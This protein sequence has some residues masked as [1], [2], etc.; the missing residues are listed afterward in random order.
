[1]ALRG[2]SAIPSTIRDFLGQDSP[3]LME[4]AKVAEDAATIAELDERY[5]RARDDRRQYEGEWLTNLAFVKGQQW[6]EWSKQRQTLYQKP[7]PPWRIRVTVNLTQPIVRTLLGK[8]GAQTT[9]GRVQANSDTPEANMDA[10]AQDE[11][12]AH[13]RHVC[14]SEET[15]S[16]ALKW[17]LIA[18]T[19]IHHLCWDKS[20]GD[21]VLEPDTIMAESIDPMTGQPTQIEQPNPN[22]GQPLRE[23]PA[24]VAEGEDPKP[25]A[26]VHMGEIDHMPVSPLQFFPEPMAKTIDDAEWCFHV[27][28]RPSSYVMRKYGKKVEEERI[29][30]DDYLQITTDETAGQTKGVVVK[31]YWERPNAENPEGRYVVF[32]GQEVLVSGPNP[33]PKFPLPFIVERDPLIPDS[34]W[35]RALVADLVPLQRS[36]NKLKSQASEIRESIA[37]PKWHRFKNTMDAGVP[38]TTAPAEVIESIFQPTMPDGGRPT[39]IVGGDVPISYQ[40]EA[41]AIERQFFE[42]A[43]LHDFRQGTQGLAGGKTA[44]GL[45]LLIEQDD[46]R[47]G[48]L[49]REHDKAVLAS[50]TAMLKL[51]KQFYIEPRTVTVVGPD[52]AVEVNE[53]YS[54]KISDDPQ[55]RLVASGNL[56]TSMAARAEYIK[57]L[58]TTQVMPGSILSDPRAIRKLLNLADVSGVKDT[59]ETDIRQ[60]ER[61]NELMKQG[62]VPAAHNYD[63]H[64]VHGQEHDDY[65]KGEEYEQIAAKN[66][67]IEQAFTQHVEMHKQLIAE[68]MKGMT[69]PAAPVAA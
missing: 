48:V 33:Y 35:G 64:V 12:L 39:K 50:Q 47:V 27:S 1:M 53:F 55:V 52:L 37:R 14:K 18:G 44:T 21:E 26:V 23:Q 32:A 42:I 29:A 28:V 16:E 54:E 31:S 19:G 9:Q 30:A 62:Q 61:E 63:N 20:I 67:A 51:A 5:K 41:A 3:D 66:P 49:K 34:F 60:A 10:R 6:T 43:G 36:Y 24:P 7:S 25:G 46:T 17:M 68:A 13:L 59:L 2:L 65:R 22:A 15:D 58:V 69:P 45:Q 56:P 4:K 40:T 11:L 57:S 8:I 38:I